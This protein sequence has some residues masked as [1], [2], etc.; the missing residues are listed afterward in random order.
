MSEGG[1]TVKEFVKYMRKGNKTI[2]FLSFE[3]GPEFIGT[4]VHEDLERAQAM[5]YQD[6]KKKSQ[7][8]SIEALKLYN[9][10]KKSK[11]FYGKH[12]K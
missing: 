4:G 2:C 8:V 10:W 3:K 11:G 6:A 1:A 7:V 9:N 5:A 12:K